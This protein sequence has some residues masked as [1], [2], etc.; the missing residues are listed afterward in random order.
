M[1]SNAKQ[2]KTQL[3]LPEIPSVRRHPDSATRMDAVMVH[4]GKFPS[5]KQTH[6]LHREVHK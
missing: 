3:N 4:V 2:N 5:P 6:R 1:K